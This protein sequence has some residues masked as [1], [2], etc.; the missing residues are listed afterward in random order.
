MR[1]L[2]ISAL[3]LGAVFRFAFPTD[4][5]WDSDVDYMVERVRAVG[6]TESFP[7]L[8]MPS[9][10]QVQNPGMSVWIFLLLGKLSGAKD[11]VR[12][13]QAVQ[14]LNWLALGLLAF[15]ALKVVKREERD[16]WIWATV[17]AC[18]NPL[19]ILYH[20]KVWAQSV[21]PFFCVLYLWAWW[22]KKSPVGAFFLAFMGLC[23]AQ[24]HMS[25]FFF[26]FGT[27]AWAFLFQRKSLH[28]KGWIAGA[29]AGFLPM[30]PWV[31]YFLSNRPKGAL[32]Y[33]LSEV[34][35]FKFWVFWITNPLG[36]HLG[37]VLGV[38]KGDTLWK[39]LGDFFAEPWMGDTPTYL[40]GIL[41]ALIL[42]TGIFAFLKWLVKGIRKKAEISTETVRAED[43]W[44]WGYGT[45]L[46]LS[47]I[48]IR[49]YY[50]L[51]TFPI[52]WAFLVRCWKESFGKKSG[53]FLFALFIA[54][55]FI[56]TQVLLF[57]HKNGGARDGAYGPS[58]SAQKAGVPRR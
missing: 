17:L 12:L 24:I 53:R 23:L 10:V 43:A 14:F 54:Q 25:G 49:R 57:L 15:F 45:A 19:A 46:T 33:H 48:C 44:T 20:R 21:L 18:V 55:I 6:V 31:H 22:K 56:S 51:I 11:A 27:I 32:I 16:T 7:L 9:A 58:Y 3:L 42:L 50:M 8:G 52:E 39:Q 4:I 36:L 30:I 47:S 41:H 28:W 37:N 29:I 5:E 13:S 2:L 34:L 38:Y 1:L 26:T 35:Q 40:V